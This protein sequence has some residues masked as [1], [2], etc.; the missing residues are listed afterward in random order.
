VKLAICTVTP[1]GYIHSAAFGEVA[2]TLR[3]AAV[4]LGHDAVLTSDSNLPGFRTIVLGTNLL[5]E[6]PQPL[7]QN[8]IL[9][10]LEQVQPG[11]WF[12]ERVLTLFRQYELWDYSASNAVE[13]VR[14]GLPRPLVVP[15][16]WETSLRRIERR[17]E[18]IDVLFYGCI[19]ERRQRVLDSLTK[20]GINVKT[21]FGV[22]GRARD[23]VIARAKIVL[24]VHFYEAK[25]FEIVRTSYL[26][27]NGRLVLSE[28][29]ANREEEAPFDAGIAFADYDQLVPR[30]L[31]LL[32][33]PD[34]RERIASTGQKL[35]ES[36]KETVYLEE[37][38][39]QLGSKPDLLPRKPPV[40]SIG[41]RSDRPVPTYYG[42]SRPEVV[43]KVPVPGTTIL[44]VGC[45]AGV[46]GQALLD[47]GAREVVGL[48]V[49]AEAASLARSRISAAYRYDVNSAFELPYP[50]HYFDVFTFADV[51]EH[52]VEPEAV[53]RRLLRWLKPGGH[54]VCSIPNVR[55]ESVL[56][57][58]LVDGK[59][60]YTDAGIL[61]QTHLRFFTLSSIQQFIAS[62]G[63]LIDPE[64]QGVM[65]KPSPYLDKTAALVQ[66]LGGNVEQFRREACVVQYL[67]TATTPNQPNVSLP[68]PI[69]DPWR[70]SRPYRLLLAPDW[71]NE[72]DC[73]QQVLHRLAE[74]DA[75]EN[76][77]TVGVTI[78]KAMLEDLPQTIF[79]IASKQILDLVLIEAPT[80][81]LGWERLLA[82]THSIAATS[83]NAR[84]REL[85][86]KVGVE[87]V[88]ST[89][90]LG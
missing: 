62:V 44:D 45:A 57:P 35:M 39:A 33:N 19:N 3:A 86:E 68:K 22:Y 30:C 55:N 73:W 47:R 83:T 63:L 67:V 84:L 56:L 85:A 76:T 82:G 24:N 6:H 61:D 7:A 51:L 25:V 71:N 90:L 29:G 87:V 66:S 17:A 69:P 53:L 5:L 9:Y 43:A 8:A 36:R 79:A 20:R 58:L 42:W 60:N 16:G 4:A 52:L 12:N 41:V 31:E 11:P 88:E 37:A 48:E 15:I 75:L 1:P 46:M 14:L 64:I 34:E 70:G 59:W 78:P 81:P 49:V 40:L 54:V 26:L 38:L 65:S 32:A 28:R 23:E 89:A 27:G 74:P 2:E 50:D 80:D 72:K 77:V 10:N 18:D 13:F 21:L